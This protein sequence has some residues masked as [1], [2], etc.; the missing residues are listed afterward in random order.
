M[1]HVNLTQVKALTDRI[2]NEKFGI[3]YG[4]KKFLARNTF[5]E[6]IYLRTNARNIIF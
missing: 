3:P 6:C 2:M 1:E 4:M 5:S